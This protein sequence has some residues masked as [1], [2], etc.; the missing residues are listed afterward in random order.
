MNKVKINTGQYQN[1]YMLKSESGITLMALII[2]IVV[3]LII[4]G[5]SVNYGISSLDDTR[6]RGFYSELEIIQKN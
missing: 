4:V 3:M 2:T 6:L 1:K 5:I